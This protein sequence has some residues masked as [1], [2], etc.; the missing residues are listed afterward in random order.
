MQNCTSA[1]RRTTNLLLSMLVVVIGGVGPGLHFGSNRSAV[2]APL[3]QSDL[4]GAR[5]RARDAMKEGRWADA[6]DAWTVVLTAAPGDP[7]ALGGIR[8]AQMRRDEGSTIDQF[9]QDVDLRKQKL[10]IEF[11]ADMDRAQQQLRNGDYGGAQRSVLTAK[12]KVERERGVLPQSLYEDL[13]TQADRLLDQVKS[14]EIQQKLADQKTQTDT[15]SKAVQ[16]S[17]R[18]EREKRQKTINELLIRVRQLQMEM[19]YQEALQVLEQILFIDPGN[20]AALALQDIIGTTLMYRNYS[21][22]TRNRSLGYARLSYEALRAA[23]PSRVNLSGEGDRSVQALMVYPED[24]PTLTNMRARYGAGKYQEPEKN[25]A[26]LYELQTKEFGVNFNRNPFEQVV[27]YLRQVTGLDFYVDWKSLEDLSVRP[28]DEITLEMP[29]ITGAQ[30]LRRVL[31]QLGDDSNAPD[32][33]VEDG[34]VVISTRS[35]LNRRVVTVVYDIRDLIFEIPYFDNAP[36][37]NLNQGI[38]QGGGGSGGGGGGGGGSPVG[39]STRKELRDPRERI[40]DIIEI[41]QEQVDPESWKATGGDV[42]NIRQLND[43]LIITTTP[44]NHRE[45]NDLLSQLRSVRALQINIEARVITVTVDWFEQIGIDF[46]IYFNTNTSMYNAA[47]GVDPNF[48][49]R[50]FFFQR[51]PNSGAPNPNVGRLKNPVV[52]DSFSGTNTGAGLPG[53][54]TATGAQLGIPS[55]GPPPT[56]ITYRTL[57]VGTPIGLQP[58]GAAVTDGLGNLYGESNGFSPVQIQQ[59]GLPLINQL[60]AAGL[61]AGS[62][63]ALALVNPVLTVGMTFLDD[64]QV[65][66]LVRATQADQRNV[67]LTAPRLTLF[68][69]Q[70]SW[71]SV[72]KAITYVSNV[73]PIAGD[74]SGA[75]APQIGVVYEGFVLDIEA[76]CSADRRYVTMT[77]QFGL[78]QNVKFTTAQSQGAAGG[79]GGTGGGGGGATRF[80]ATIQLPELQGT[81]INTTVSVPDKGTILLGGQ[82]LFN[83]IE[84]EVGVP[85]LSKIPVV[86]RFFTNR[87]STKSETTL[88]L[89]IRPEILIQQEN[90]DILFPGLQDRMG[91]AAAT[92]YGF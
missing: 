38:Q 44:K 49:L 88:L 80:T 77:V 39:D 84:I 87:L 25:Q 8:D 89:L 74:N 4:D 31:E 55:G 20:P 42:G 28:E 34:Q 64:I 59:E 82:R 65:D 18:L 72:A 63:G 92:G 19:K 76:V 7:E 83:E 45:I 12:V 40:Q 66:L 90:E 22:I 91:S 58:K 13:T 50:D 81:T 32:Y 37:F 57:P 33:S 6:I 14:A 36:D 61:S 47:R 52:F 62:V 21:T 86:N 2:A 70:R 56:D 85:V 15:A 30:A 5:Q 69:G 41:I 27:G 67:V 79:G 68:N 35:A 1:T 29:S 26:T 43:N 10:Q 46:D 71:I 54:T 16:D 78:N 17:Q 9:Q 23:V 51:D 75:F 73:Q 24:W 53:N 11:N 3:M 48:Q 60:A